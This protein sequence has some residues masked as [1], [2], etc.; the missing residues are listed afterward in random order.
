MYSLRLPL[1]RI[2]LGSPRS[3]ALLVL[4]VLV[5][6]ACAPL[7]AQETS[8][9]A[10][11]PAGSTEPAPE[12]ERLGKGGFPAAPVDGRWLVDEAGREYF[13]HELHKSDVHVVRIDDET[14]RTA[15]GMRMK[16]AG[17]DDEVYYIKIFKPV[18]VAKSGP[19]APTEEELAQAAKA[20]QLEP[21]SSDRLQ[22]VPFDEGLPKS[23]HW[24]NGFDVADMNGD[25]HLDILHSTPRKAAGGPRIFLGNSR[26]AWKLWAEVSWPKAP[27]DYGDT[28][29]A[30]FNGDGHMDVAVAVHLRGVMA[31]VGDGRGGFSLWSEGIDIEGPDHR[32]TPAFTSRALA[33]VDWNRDGRPDILVFSEGPRG[34]QHVGLPNS[35]GKLIYINQGDGTWRKQEEPEPSRIYGDAIAVGDFNG[36]DLIDFA[37]SS[38]VFAQKDL[39]NLGR[40]DGSWE[41]VAIDGIRRAAWAWAVGAGDFDGDGKDDLAVA[42]HN[43][44]LGVERAGLDLLLA[45]AEGEWE[46][47]PIMVTEEERINLH[48][49]GVGDVDGDGLL[50]LV[51]LSRHGQLF[52]FRGDGKGG[53]E[54][55]EEPELERVQLECRGFHV[56][57]VD[58]DRD[59]KDEI[60]ASFA[61]E[62][63]PGNG[64]LHAWRTEVKSTAA[65]MAGEA[66]SENAEAPGSAL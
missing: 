5:A 7:R 32:G 20:Y 33:T 61:G 53:F 54:Q 22:L 14:I 52:L 6:A 4:A 59:G 37:T 13:V 27:F 66:A 44:E 1:S 19:P 40:E 12:I 34:F 21:V 48:A 35:V 10:E 17:E 56:A 25:G 41:T 55:E 8:A 57:L 28:A 58:L 62:K 18:A 9:A 65:S 42:Y 29:A 24:R 49:L 60:L 46:R 63:C 38:N 64:S 2:A 39:V 15:H 26:G 43:R 47:R 50:D 3:V 31:L 11:P 16:L 51:A 23:G 36:D 30:D 45:K